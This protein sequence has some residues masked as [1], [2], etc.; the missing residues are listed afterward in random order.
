MPDLPH[1]RKK[2]PVADLTK[3]NDLADEIKRQRRHQHGDTFEHLSRPLSRVIDKM[4]KD[5]GEK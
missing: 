5:W 4:A 3:R 1:D 2:I